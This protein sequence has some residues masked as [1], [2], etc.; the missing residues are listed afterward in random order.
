MDYEGQSPE[1]P[2]KGFMDVGLEFK[3]ECYGDSK[4]ILKN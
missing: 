3:N 4:E 1:A 2:G